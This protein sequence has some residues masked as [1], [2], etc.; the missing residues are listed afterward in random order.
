MRVVQALHWLRDQL[1]AN[2]PQLRKRLGRIL[3]DP[4]HGP[5]IVADLRDGLGAMPAWMQAFVRRLLSDLGQ[6]DTADHRQRPSPQP[7]L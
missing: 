1:A 7:Q 5:A 6:D 2:G 4:V 3:R